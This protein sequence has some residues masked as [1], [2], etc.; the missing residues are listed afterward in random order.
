MLIKNI[1]EKLE[2]YKS[3]LKEN[4]ECF[5]SIIIGEVPGANMVF[6]GLPAEKRFMEM[7]CDCFLFSD[8]WT[9]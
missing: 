7:V 5:I 9:E 8:F 4:E 6:S 1:E 3:I 2:F